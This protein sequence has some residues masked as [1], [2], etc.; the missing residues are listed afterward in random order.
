MRFL[1]AVGYAL[2]PAVGPL[3]P[4]VVALFTSSN[5]LFSTRS[6]SALFSVASIIHHVVLILRLP[7]LDVDD[8]F[9]LNNFN[10]EI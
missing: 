3:C 9:F 1:P 4:A 6:G 10:F 8:P 2:S 7:R 5:P